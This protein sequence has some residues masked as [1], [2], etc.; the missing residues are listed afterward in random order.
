MIP[1]NIKTKKEQAINWSQK[2]FHFYDTFCKTKQKGV[3]HEIELEIFIRLI[4][5]TI[6]NKNDQAIN[7]RQKYFNFCDIF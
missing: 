7:S 4:L 3:R 6:I 2:C 1:C 5:F